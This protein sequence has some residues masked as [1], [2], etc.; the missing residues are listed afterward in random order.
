MRRFLVLPIALIAALWPVMTVGAAPSASL[1]VTPTTVPAGGS[2]QVSGTCDPNTGGFAISHA[3]LHDAAHD[4][5][6]VGAV[7]FDTDSS[8]NF[9]VAAKIPTSI[10]PGS[11]QVGARCGGGN[12]GISVTLTVTEAAPTG[13]PAGSGGLAAS[14]S[15]HDQRQQRVLL[16]LGLALLAISGLGVLRLRRARR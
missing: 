12:L 4:F 7:H 14:T 8:G 3:F 9:S 15:P 5:A 1:H 6:G 11:Y 2:V 10:P 13:V 16:G